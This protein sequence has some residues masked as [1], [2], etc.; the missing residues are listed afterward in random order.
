MMNEEELQQI[1]S[2]SD[3]SFRFDCGFSKVISM[4]NRHELLSIAWKHYVLYSVYAEVSELR[5]GLLNTLNLKQFPILSPKVLHQL[6]VAENLKVIDAECLQ[7][8]FV[9]SFSVPGSNLRTVESNIPQL[10]CLS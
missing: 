8:L 10:V 2:G 1:L 7:D 5:N 9:P 6:L 4:E 3:Y